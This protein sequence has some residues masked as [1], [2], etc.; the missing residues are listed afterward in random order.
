MYRLYAQLNFAKQ[1]QLEM[2]I[3][4]LQQNNMSVQEFYSAMYN[5][6]DQLASIEPPDLSV[7]SNYIKR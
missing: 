6:W 2:D 4:A 1:Y 5:L 3:H 7:L